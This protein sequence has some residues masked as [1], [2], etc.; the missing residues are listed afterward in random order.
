MTACSGL[1]VHLALQEVP[2]FCIILLR[3]DRKCALV[4][5][6]TAVIFISHCCLLLCRTY[7]ANSAGVDAAFTA[8]CES[9]AGLGSQSGSAVGGFNCEEK[10]P[11]I[12]TTHQYASIKIWEVECKQRRQEVGLGSRHRALM[13]SNQ[14][15]EFPAKVVKRPNTLAA[16]RRAYILDA[17][18]RS[19]SA[20]S[21]F[22]GRF[23]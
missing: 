17:E 12:H 15:G 23:S 20:V 16:R 2:F 19:C 13:G 21:Q 5:A 10:C 7:L 6:V 3:P 14:G 4:A 1:K 8:T 9:S 18:T 11:T 22:C